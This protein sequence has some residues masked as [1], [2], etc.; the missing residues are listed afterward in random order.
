MDL[1][2]VANAKGISKL[3][4]EAGMN[5]EHLYKILS[6]QGNPE[7]KSLSSILRTLGLRLSVKV[8]KYA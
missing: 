1:K 4:C 5:R 6:T 8:E 3:A 7:L 2:D